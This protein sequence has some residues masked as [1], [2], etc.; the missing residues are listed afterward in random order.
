MNFINYKNKKYPSFQA[1]G[2]AAQFI[3]PFAMKFCVGEGYDIGCCKKEWALPNSIPIDI[4]FNN[5]FDAYKLPKKSVD[6][7]FSSH[8]LEHLP[9]WVNALEYWLENLKDG[10]IL[11]LY[12]PDYSQEYWRPW[13]NKKHIHCLSSDILKDFLIDRNMKNI[14]ISGIDLN[15]SFCIVAE[16]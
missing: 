8:C 4:K 6:Y 14:L 7:I 15:N 5:D 1:D 2:F 13:N 3:F 9:N 11:F 10:G 16:K 12:L